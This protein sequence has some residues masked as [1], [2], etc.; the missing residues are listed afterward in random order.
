VK[1]D[2]GNQTKIKHYH[3]HEL[4]TGSCATETLGSLA[5][6]SRCSLRKPHHHLEQRGRPRLKRALQVGIRE[7]NCRTRGD[8]L[9][10]HVPAKIAGRTGRK[11]SFR[12]SGR[13]HTKH[14]TQGNP[15]VRMELMRFR[16]RRLV[17]NRLA[18]QS[19]HLNPISIYRFIDFA[20][21]DAPLTVAVTPK[22]TGLKPLAARCF[23]AASVQQAGTA[24]LRR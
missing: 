10:V 18:I 15:D 4:N 20:P 2:C 16:F 9:D 7:D 11:I 3:S 23:A 8:V 14:R 21:A 22:P 6:A 19:I 12:W 17:R 1:P 5:R 24:G 13:H